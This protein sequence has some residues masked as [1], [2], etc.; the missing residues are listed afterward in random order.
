[1]IAPEL[2]MLI[3]VAGPVLAVAAVAVG[4]LNGK[5]TGPKYDD[6]SWWQAIK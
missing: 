4:P 3:G 1:M 6:D 5:N 2:F